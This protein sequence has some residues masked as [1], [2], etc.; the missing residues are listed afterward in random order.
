LEKLA[1]GLQGLPVTREY[2]F[3]VYKDVILSGGFYWS[4]HVDELSGE[5]NPDEVPIEFLNKIIDKIQNTELSEPPNFYVLDVAKT[6]SGE[7][8]L[9]EVNDGSMSGLSENNPEVL[10]KNLQREL[11]KSLC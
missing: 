1:E 4:S 6:Q 7:W 9:V 3:F 2:R 11:I 8:I 5:V 10:Y